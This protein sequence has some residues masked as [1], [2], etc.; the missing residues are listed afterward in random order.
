MV[1]RE[2]YG[3]VF[4]LEL[5]GLYVGFICVAGGEIEILGFGDVKGT[6]VI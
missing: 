1:V 6:D 2:V 3:Y 4:E 5:H